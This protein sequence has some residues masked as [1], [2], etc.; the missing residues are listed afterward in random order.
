[1]YTLHMLIDDQFELKWDK[2]NLIMG[3]INMR[4]EKM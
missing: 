3:A 1:M 2:K 4:N